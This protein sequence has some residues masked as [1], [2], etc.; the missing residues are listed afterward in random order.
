MS[1]H[2][3]EKWVEEGQSSAKDYPTRIVL[4]FD[5]GLSL[6]YEVGAER[7]LKGE[8]LAAWKQI[9]KQFPGITLRPLYDDQDTKNLLML[10]ERARE[11]DPNYK[12]PDFLTYFVI[13]MPAGFDGSELAKLL[14]AMPGVQTAYVDAGPVEPPI[15]AANDPRFSGQGYL[16]AAP[17]GIDAR[18]AWTQPGGDGL[19]VLFVDLEQGWALNH[20]DLVAVQ[21]SLISG[22]N[23][24]YIGHGTSVLGEVVAVD[25]GVGGV[26]IAPQ[27]WAQVVSQWRNDGSYNTAAAIASAAGVMSRGDVLLLE[28][29]VSVSGSPFL[30]VEVEQA[31]FDAIRLA[32]A[33]GIVV[34]EAAGNG[35]V[36]L[37]RYTDAMGRLLL[38]RTDRNF[39]DSGAIMVGAAIS[40]VPHSRWGG[41]NFGSRVDCYGWGENIDTTDWLG[42]GT[43]SYRS[44][45]GGT[46]GASAMIAGAA[47]L[48]QSLSFQFRRR[49]YA[50]SGLRAVLMEPSRGTASANP[51]ADRIG[52]MPDLRMIIDSVLNPPQRFPV[53][54]YRAM[55]QILFG[56]V[57][58]GPGVVIGPDGNPIPEGPWDPTAIRLSAEYV[59]WL[60]GMA[61]TEFSKIISDDMSAKEVRQAGLALM[62]R[63]L[64]QLKEPL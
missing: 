41:S 7:A 63:A 48:V 4:K 3:E 26:G 46:S 54:I 49:R 30:P 23:R 33:A 25:N 57:N 64:N 10:V 62:E 2:S 15:N 31:S 1:D 43:S 53:D 20:E 50:P 60:T 61:L 21:I 36:D 6:P 19:G 34:I 8:M 40:R 59:D 56:V 9:A 44:T 39:R 52:V 32:V 35:A 38:N 13:Q 27:A 47:L 51:G 58:D 24:D 28:A 37:D 16:M 18:Y 42:T 17:Q 55:V 45:F 29:Q 14:S 5:D 12:A 11:N 22:M